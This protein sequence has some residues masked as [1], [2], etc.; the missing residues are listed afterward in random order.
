MAQVVN[1][2]LR[3]IPAWPLYVIGVLPPAWLLWA[4]FSGRLG[5][6]PVKAMEHQMG[7]W[8]LWLLIAGLCVTPL[9]RYIGINLL[10]YR[11]ALGL[12]TFFYI[13]CH[14]LIWLILDVQILSLIWE[15]ILRR[16]YITVGMGAF[17]LMTPLAI[18]SNNLSIRKMGRN[19]R[20]LHKLV[21][22]AALLG[23]LHYILLAKG[24]QLP[25]FIY[26]GVIIALLLLRLPKV[27]KRRSH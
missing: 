23:A 8:G 22:G 11:R 20:R 6:D 4:G 9:R 21:Y 10:R 17:A 3:R 26:M 15:D 27:A 18:T 1:T 12:L 5:F 7:E 24:F 16:P 13:F 14:L 25:P 19:W 2:W